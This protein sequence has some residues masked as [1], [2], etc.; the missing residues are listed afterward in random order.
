MKKRL[1]LLGMAFFLLLGGASVTQDAGVDPTQE[2]L[3]A[4][5]DQHP[6]PIPGG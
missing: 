1:V 4:T 5:K 6:D 2:V 3:L